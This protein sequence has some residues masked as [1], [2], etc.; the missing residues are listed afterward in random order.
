MNKIL[1]ILT[2]FIFIFCSSGP[3]LAQNPRYDTSLLRLT[4]ILGSLHYIS[5]LCG[6]ETEKWRER[7]NE[8]IE[9]EKPDAARLAIFYAVFND[10]Y[11]SF[12]ENYRQCTPAAIEAGNRYKQEGQRLTQELIKRYGN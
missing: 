2:L 1:K 8:L 11:Q 3:G 10:A 4:E 5:N 6:L 12:A 9:A 7:M